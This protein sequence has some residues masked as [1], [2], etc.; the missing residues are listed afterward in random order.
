MPFTHEDELCELDPG[1]PLIIIQFTQ[2]DVE[3]VA[4]IR[5][6]ALRYYLGGL[7]ADRAAKAMID[8]V[9]QDGTHCDLSYD[10]DATLRIVR[11]ILQSHAT[12]ASA[13]ED[14]AA[15]LNTRQDETEMRWAELFDTLETLEDGWWLHGKGKAPTAK[16]IAAT[17]SLVDGVD[18]LRYMVTATTCGGVRFVTKEP[19]LV[20][21]RIKANGKIIT[22]IM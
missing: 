16:A 18:V 1:A 15:L 4:Q 3:S 22:E 5:R 2:A 10:A 12:A 6:L 14:I 20:G 9:G 21:F 19:G 7:G 11:C 17:R 8:I 13:L